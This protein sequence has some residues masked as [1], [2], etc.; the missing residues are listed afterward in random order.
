MLFVRPRLSGRLAMDG[1]AQWANVPAELQARRQWV[2]WRNVVRDGAAA[3]VPF[4]PDGGGKAR[5]NDPSTWGTFAAAVALARREPERYAGIGFVFTAD[6]PYVGV[7]LDNCLSDGRVAEW[8]K[9][10]ME[11][12]RGAYVETSPS[13]RGMKLWVR[14][15]LSG[16]GG[17]RKIGQ[18]AHTAIEVYGFGRYFAT[19]GDVLSRPHGEIPDR[20]PAVDALY[21]WVRAE[22][23]ERASGGASKA[24]PRRSRIADRSGAWSAERRAISY[25]ERVDG[26]VSGQ[27]GHDVTYRAA[28]ALVLGFGLSV[29]VAFRLLRDSYNPR[30]SPPW[31]EVELKHKVEDADEEEG[32][33]GY[34]L[35]AERGDG[36]VATI[37]A[38]PSTA[39]LEGVRGLD[40][41]LALLSRTDLG[42]SIRLVERFRGDLRF[43]G[44]WGRWLVW[45]GRRYAVDE[46]GAAMRLA[47]EAAR[48]ILAEA[49]TIDDPDERKAHTAWAMA[50]QSR[51]RIESMLALAASEP[52]VPIGVEEM[53]QDGWLLNCPNG[54][55][56]LRTGELHPHRRADLITQICPVDFDPDAECPLW[57]ST[58]GLFFSGDEKLV[59]YWQRICGYALVGEVR[60]HVL[61]VAYGEGSNGK[62]TIL[63]TLLNVLGKDYAMKAPPSLL[64]A[65][66]HD[67]HPVDKADL[68]ARRLVVAIETG[69]GRRLDET[70]VKELTGGDAIRAR[71]MRENFWEYEPTHTI[72]MATNHK[73]VIRGADNGIWRRMRLV[74]FLVSLDGSAAD[75]SIPSKLKE[76][77]AGILAWCV[78]GCLAWQEVGL[79]E[80]DVVAQATAEYRAE[81]DVLGEFLDERAVLND[82]VR[83]RCID[84]YSGYQ[85]WAESRGE[86]PMSLRAFGEGM[87]RRGI[88][89]KTSNGKW[90]LGVGL[91]PSDDASQG[92][93]G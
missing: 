37:E 24:A 82:S 22:R 42:N 41:R 54:T 18:D 90:Y 57:E 10:W 19:T 6:D 66:S 20:Q 73:P 83:T 88:E 23:F 27:G 7:D 75:T 81:Q 5:S 86:H 59:A 85:T 87:R 46:S 34:L 50:S 44:A 93:G 39:A 28:C 30:C 1:S 31:S 80:P 12:F 29:E 38:S 49:A 89:T 26:A 13:G 65:K 67:P 47:K 16:P 35:D 53:N 55:V 61:I 15:R 48:C 76:E 40:A 17:S 68:F 45:D 56:D 64:M 8:A 52:D 11:M 72:V 4:R 69:E 78:R 71:R 91:R 79:S 58:L 33:R 3:K 21:A 84:V 63:G 60:D 14:G 77:A 62:S 2:V 74:P 25:L 92:W 9:P 51:A 70:A 36:S 43:C 32:D